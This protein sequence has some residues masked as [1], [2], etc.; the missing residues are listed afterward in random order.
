MF[1]AEILDV[2]IIMVWAIICHLIGGLLSCVYSVLAITVKCVWQRRDCFQT[3]ILFT[4][5][6]VIREIIKAPRDVNGF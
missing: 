1:L 2:A 4:T 6:V 5:N 3:L